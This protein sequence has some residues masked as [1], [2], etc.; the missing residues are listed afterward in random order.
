MR[1]REDDDDDNYDDDVV[2]DD[3]SDSSS[4]RFKAQEVVAVSVISQDGD[5]L[6]LIKEVCTFCSRELVTIWTKEVCTFWTKE[7]VTIWTK[8]VCTF[9]SWYY[10]LMFYFD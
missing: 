10:V 4:K 7:L 2:K 6:S 1:D 3:D 5:Y 9:L 8:E